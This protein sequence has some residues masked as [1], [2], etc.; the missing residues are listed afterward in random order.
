MVNIDIDLITDSISENLKE[1]LSN[2]PYGKVIDYKIT[3]GT[4]IGL[5]I[6]LNNGNKIWI[7]EKEIAGCQA[8]NHIN[9]SD[10]MSI[11]K[12]EKDVS[13]HNKDLIYVLNPLNLFN[14]VIYSLKDVY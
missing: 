5:V 10:G 6:E 11:I 4:S 14:W 13:F 7:F 1:Y 3:D 12:I 9:Q 8:G 2:H